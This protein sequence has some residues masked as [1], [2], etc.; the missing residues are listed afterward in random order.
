MLFVTEP[1]CSGRAKLDAFTSSPELGSTIV[2]HTKA[3][4][5]RRRQLSVAAMGAVLAA[6]VVVGSVVLR[7]QTQRSISPA[8]DSVAA[9]TIS[10][11]GAPSPTQA[12][13]NTEIVATDPSGPALTSSA[14][15]SS[16]YI[17]DYSTY[18][19]TERSLSG[20]VLRTFAVGARATDLQTMPNGWVIA[21]G[22]SVPLPTNDQLQN[23][24]PCTNVALR[25]D[26]GDGQFT[27][28]HPDLPAARHIAIANGQLFAVRD[29]CPAG[30]VWGD[31]GTGWAL[32]MI[33]LTSPD[34][35]A[36]SRILFES[37]LATPGVASSIVTNL[38]VSPD[39]FRAAI[40]LS[41]ED[42]GWSVY[43]VED[44]WRVRSNENPAV[45]FDLGE[46]RIAGRPTFLDS[47]L[48]VVPCSYMDGTFGAAMT[49]ADGSII[50]ERK[51]EGSVA[52]QATV[53]VFVDEASPENPY[54]LVGG[55]SNDPR[56]PKLT[57]FA[58]LHDEGGTVVASDAVG[59]GA[60]T[61]E[62]LGIEELG[63][64]QEMEASAT[65]EQRPGEALV[66]RYDSELP[67]A[68]PE[69]VADLGIAEL[70]TYDL[71]TLA[72]FSAFGT[73]TAVVFDPATGVVVR[74]TPRGGTW[75]NVLPIQDPAGAVWDIELGPERYDPDNGGPDPMLYVSRVTSNGG[76]GEVFTLVAYGL[77]N[78]NELVN[79][80]GRWDTAW[81]CQE[82]FCGNIVF[83]PIGVDLGNGLFAQAGTP[84][85]PTLDQ[86][87]RDT[88]TP[89]A[90]ANDCID[91]A[92]YNLTATI[93]QIRFAGRSWVLATACVQVQEGSYTWFRPQPDGSVLAMLVIKRLSS[94]NGRY[95]L[96]HLRA[97]GTTAA[98][99]IPVTYRDVAF[100]EDRLLA[101]EAV[102]N[103]NYRVVELVPPS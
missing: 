76:F 64:V 102:P 46:C 28:L 54:M 6:L 10:D 66:V 52:V 81:L 92:G 90:P 23:T 88:G 70:A 84:V 2:A 35:S 97:D 12:P 38:I 36:P 1:I 7:P 60:W 100:V 47:Q 18:T 16:F 25:A 31:P 26:H 58:L 3:R 103:G 89:E 48:I 85:S 22:D 34:V 62:E 43:S 5:R 19:A 20:T 82:T 95:V 65:P 8:A 40:E 45:R 55:V 42:Y 73:G 77:S 30:A 59:I 68:P 91:D 57:V 61:L 39:G 83:T 69:L 93:E 98:Y 27:D 94:E 44:Q 96:A 53:S 9:T 14:P 74:S 32:D 67:G 13:P 71:S 86:P 41:G 11:N 56:S 4:I 29:V 50:W 101:I 78:D 49:Y 15:P 72:E 21:L 75:R 37:A 24:P 63:P 33:D 79:E 17:V 99:D 87:G 51:V 80:F